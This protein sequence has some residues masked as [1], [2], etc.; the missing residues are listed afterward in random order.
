MKCGCGHE[1]KLHN[2][3]TDFCKVDGCGCCEFI[4]N[5]AQ[6]QEAK[7]R[8]DYESVEDERMWDEVFRQ[9][10]L[11]QEDNEPPSGST[12]LSNHGGTTFCY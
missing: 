7:T 5:V 1:K 12:D 10:Q 11:E 4:S 3:Q 2:H 9:E 6:W 8:W